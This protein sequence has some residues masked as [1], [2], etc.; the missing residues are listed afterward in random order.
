[1]PCAAVY[2][3]LLD[4]CARTK[5]DERGYEV[6]DRMH[7]SDVATDARTMD[8]VRSRKSLRSHLKRVF[9]EDLSIPNT[10]R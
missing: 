1:M 6:I 8:A 4:I 3:S 10:K 5:D 2:N 7:R 9:G